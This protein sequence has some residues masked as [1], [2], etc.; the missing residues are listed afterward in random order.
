MDLNDD[1][2]IDGNYSAVSHLVLERVTMVVWLDVSLL[3]ATFQL[4][5]RTLRRVFTRTELWNGNREGIGN[6]CSL[7]PDKSVLAWMFKTHRSFPAR[8]EDLKAESG[9]K[10]VVFHRIRTGAQAKA[11]LS[12]IRRTA[13]LRDVDGIDTTV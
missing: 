7:N 3:R 4:G 6:L 1:W 12:S 9:L 11:L 5:C 8:Y 13:G 2:V 10:A